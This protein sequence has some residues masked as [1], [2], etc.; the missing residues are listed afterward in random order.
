MSKIDEKYIA[1]LAGFT[2]SLDTIVEILES[3]LK[4]KTSDVVNDFL[5][6]FPTNDVLA[7]VKNIETLSNIF[8]NNSD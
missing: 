7:K 5:K 6:N 3:Q 2:K 8:Q 4:N 1:A